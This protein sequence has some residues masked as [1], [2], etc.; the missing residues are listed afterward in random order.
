MNK[1]LQAALASYARAA[2][3]AVAVTITAGK[4][5]PKELLAAAAIAVIAPLIRAI[6]PKDAAFG[7]IA[8]KATEEI[9][10]LA[11]ANTKKAKKK[12]A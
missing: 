4:T 6:N 8:D 3:V 2:L 10:K 5:D 9:D 7:T 12:S 11:K 1:A